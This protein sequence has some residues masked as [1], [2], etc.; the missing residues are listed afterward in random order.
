MLNRNDTGC[1][2][3]GIAELGRFLP[4]PWL[5]V[6]AVCLSACGSDP[7]VPQAEEEDRRRAG[8]ELTNAFLNLTFEAPVALSGAPAGLPRLYVALR[9][10]Y[11]HQFDNDLQ[12]EGTFAFVD[13]RD[14]VLDDGEAG[15]LRSFVFHPEVGTHGGLAV[16]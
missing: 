5:W 12:V 16:P 13:L 1:S 6:A 4:E 11:I 2:I 15:G 8:T 10:G 7:A 3:R 9:S 14:R